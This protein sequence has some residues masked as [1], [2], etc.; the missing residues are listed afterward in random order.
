ME[1][2]VGPHDNFGFDPTVRID[3]QLIKNLLKADGMGKRSQSAGELDTKRYSGVFTRQRDDANETVRVFDPFLDMRVSK[4][5]DNPFVTSKRT[6]SKQNNLLSDTF[7]V[8][9]NMF[10]KQKVM[11]SSDGFK[12]N[13]MKRSLSQTKE[14]DLSFVK[15]LITSITIEHRKYKL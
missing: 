14:I 1:S 4:G 8:I 12:G 9:H 13:S 11:H 5:A 15:N 6:T 10:G 7:K 2:G 3:P